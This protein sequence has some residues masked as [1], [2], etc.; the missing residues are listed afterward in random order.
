MAV[1]DLGSFTF[2]ATIQVQTQVTRWIPATQTY[3][4]ADPAT[5]TL[6]VRPPRGNWYNLTLALAEVKRIRKGLY[7][8]DV[9]LNESGVWRMRWSSEHGVKEV[10]VTAE[11]SPFE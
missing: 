6:A 4:D 2:G 10:I 11:P 1:E 3:V 7:Y 8:A 9:T 5:L